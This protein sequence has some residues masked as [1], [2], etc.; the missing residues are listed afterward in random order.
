MYPLKNKI[1]EYAWGSRTA[2]AELISAP[3]PSARP[4]AELWLGA[5]P[6]AP[7]EVLRS[8]GW[9]DLELW[10]RREPETV[11]GSPATRRFGPRLPFLLKVLAAEVP[12]SLQAHPNQ[13]QAEAG[14]LAEERAGIALSSAHR[15]YKD[16][17]HK[18]E[19]L[20]ALTPFHALCGFRAIDDSLRLFDALEVAAL[21]DYLKPLREA[22]NAHGLRTLVAALLTADASRARELARATAEACTARAISAPEFAAEY[23]WAARIGELCPG[24]VGI[25]TALLLNLVRL[26]PGQAI[27]LPAGKLHAYLQGVGV[28]I[29]ASSDN[30]LR[31]GLTPKHVDASELLR[32]LEFG[33]GTVTPLSPERAASGELVYQTPAPEFRLSRIDVAAERSVELSDRGG[34]EILLVTAG[35]CHARAGESLDLEKGQSAFVP[36]GSDEIRLSGT[37][38]VF[39]AKV[40]TF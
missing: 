14:F 27:F 21:S 16:R 31:G 24:D 18:P 7:S 2:I 6:S 15:N 35:R 10:I 11:L 5:H 8:D 20:C 22:R 32:I 34:P 12:L 13:A 4:Q 37:A 33:S 19:L 38:T 17:H 39:R 30:V 29:M 25:V 26:E 40:N 9:Q 28:E 3:V 1:Q 36:A 23:G